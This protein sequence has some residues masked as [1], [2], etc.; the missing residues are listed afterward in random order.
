MMFWKTFL[1]IF[2]ASIG[3]KESSVDFK[4]DQVDI[5]R[6]KFLY[7]LWETRGWN[8]EVFFWKP[9]S[10]GSTQIR[11]SGTEN[12]L[13]TWNGS[14]VCVLYWSPNVVPVVSNAHKFAAI[15]NSEI[16]FSAVIYLSRDWKSKVL[17]YFVA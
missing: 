1:T 10:N 5:T 8:V 15:S 4:I 14:P 3:E 7:F 11:L 16:V 13:K 17:L 2:S 9:I 6:L 12:N